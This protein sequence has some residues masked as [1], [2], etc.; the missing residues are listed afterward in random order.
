MN[1]EIIKRLKERLKDSLNYEFDLTF[2]DRKLLLSYI[3][4]LEKKIDQY[5]NPDDLTLFYMW[6][7]IKAK[8]KMKQ[9]EADYKEA[10]DSITWWTNR[11]NAV[12][13]DNRDYKSRIDKAIEILYKRK[14][15]E[16]LF[17]GVENSNTDKI[18]NILKGDS[19]E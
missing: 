10:N 8:D 7:D 11:Y 18:I 6:L 15:V 12:E 5:E 17:G 3:E 2:D 19:D 1:K 13:R 4:Q 14:H 9:L 16:N